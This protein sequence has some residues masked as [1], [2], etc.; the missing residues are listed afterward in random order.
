MSKKSLI[1]VILQFSSFIFF[2]L[3]GGL[4]AKGFLLFIQ[5]IGLAIGLWGI[6]TMKLGNFNIQPEVKHSAIFT[7]H[8]PYKIIRN[9]MYTGLLIFFGISVLTN[10]NS[11]RLAVLIILTTSLLLKIFME[12]QFLSNRFKNEYLEY[13]KK[14]YRLIPFIF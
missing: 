5:I 8:G 1:L 12:E 13:K 11:L 10:F 14:T 3:D 4:F 9:P 6:I 7:S 2:G